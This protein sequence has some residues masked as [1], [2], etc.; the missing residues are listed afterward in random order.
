MRREPVVIDCTAAIRYCA[1]GW[2]YLPGDKA[3]ACGEKNCRRA[4]EHDPKKLAYQQKLDA[5]QG[6]A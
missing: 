4:L 3:L 6:E 2:H 1:C 5:E